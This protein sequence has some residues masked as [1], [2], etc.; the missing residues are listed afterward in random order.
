V[1]RQ[2]PDRAIRRQSADK[3]I[4]TVL[5]SL[6]HYLCE[7]APEREA[8]A[9]A[10]TCAALSALRSAPVECDPLDLTQFQQ[11]LQRIEAELGGH[12]TPDRLRYLAGAATTT[13]TGY[14]ARANRRMKEQASQLAQMV[15]LLT[16]AIG[17][18]SAASEQSASRL[19]QIEQRLGSSLR[20]TDLASLRH[21]LEYCLDTIRAE[22]LHQRR[23]SSA[24]VTMLSR[25]LE[26][27][28]GGRKPD[29]LPVA[30]QTS[31]PPRPE[32][33][34]QTM[35]NKGLDSVTGLP[36]RAA[37]E[38]SLAAAIRVKAKIFVCLYSC[39]H[40]ALINQR[41]GRLTGD[42]ILETALRRIDD[43]LPA[44]CQLFKWSGR[45]FVGLLER[46]GDLAAVRTETRQHNSMKTDVS[47]DI[48]NRS[49][50]LPLLIT[51]QIFA[52]FE[53]K[54]ARTLFRAMDDYLYQLD[55]DYSRP[56]EAPPPGDQ[57]IVVDGPPGPD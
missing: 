35:R 36:T 24:A 55:K 52:A 47:V 13:I 40:I 22:A 57:L 43:T 17:E 34:L 53:Y 6:R 33:P 29:T 28:P 9:L 4:K 31:A 1:P 11:D 56:P 45:S 44:D 16:A 12:P 30:S 8:A 41:Y 49:V 5:D 39:Q 50:M 18:L 14:Q 19:K 7:D 2:G 10:M 54:R 48:G 15:K 42:K 25:Q 27:L 3:S 38:Q 23:S 51:T 21:S 32:A 46:D 37:A 20:L 26:V